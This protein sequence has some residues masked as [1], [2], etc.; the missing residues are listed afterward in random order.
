MKASSAVGSSGAEDIS[1][2]TLSAVQKLNERATAE[3]ADNL[4]GHSASEEGFRRAA[5][6]LLDQD[7]HRSERQC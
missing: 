2:P 6:E 1:P 3:L 4:H 5:R 7:A